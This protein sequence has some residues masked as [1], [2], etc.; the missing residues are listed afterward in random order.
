VT[1]DLYLAMSR[2]NPIEIH[3]PKD[4]SVDETFDLKGEICPYTFVK[5]KLMLEMM[6][7]GQVLQVVVDNDESATNVPKSLTNEGNTVLGCE[8]IGGTD[9]MITVRKK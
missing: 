7:S 5:S 3:A 4:I 1:C 2:W 6:E 9:W 8:K